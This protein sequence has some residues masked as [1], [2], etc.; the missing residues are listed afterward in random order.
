MTEGKS[1]IQIANCFKVSPV[2]SKEVKIA[3]IFVKMRMLK[4][5][6]NGLLFFLKMIS[7]RKKT[8]SDKLKRR[9]FI[10]KKD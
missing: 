10:I 3:I 1:F 9:K 2:I 5:K 6:E 8:R 7:K 4:Q